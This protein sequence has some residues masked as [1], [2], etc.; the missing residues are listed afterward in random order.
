[1]A[2][3]PRIA[4]AQVQELLSPFGEL[5]SQSESDWSG[6]FPLPEAVAT[7]YREIGPWEV[8]IRSHGNPYHLPKLAD[9]WR[10]QAGYR[11][12]GLSG[13][14]SADWNDDWLVVAFE[15]SNPFIFSHRS[16]HIMHAM[17]GAGEWKPEVVFPDVNTMAACLGQ[18]GTIVSS[19]GDVLTD[20]DCVVRPEFYALVVS[21]LAVLLGTSTV[22]ENVL[23]R[24][25]G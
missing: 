21:E 22:A 5:R 3:P 13:E 10:L 24:L 6:K 15:G 20:A 25:W 4:S 18:I 11:W 9:L 16:G 1:M 7:F 19:V 23:A 2:M 14:A 12:N 8:W 17:I